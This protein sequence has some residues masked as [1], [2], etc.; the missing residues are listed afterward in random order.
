[1]AI[2]ELD[3]AELDLISGGLSLAAMNL[4]YNIPTLLNDVL[5]TTN[6]LVSAVGYVLGAL[7]PVLLNLGV[8]LGGLMGTSGNTLLATSLGSLLGLGGLL[9]L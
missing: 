2:Q 6:R 7:N 3:N 5:I 1:M 4:G 8:P 9:A